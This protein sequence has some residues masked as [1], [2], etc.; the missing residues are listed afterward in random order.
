MKRYTFAIDNNFRTENTN[1]K[2]WSEILDNLIADNLKRNNSYLNYE[3]KPICANCPLKNCPLY[4]GTNLKDDLIIKAALYLSNNRN[5]IGDIR[6]EKGITYKLGS[7][8]IIFF[9][10][11]IQIGFDIFSY[12]DLRNASLLR[13]LDDTTRDTII[14]IYNITINI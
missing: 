7:T 9:D 12:D 3:T 8:P 5:R 6:C 10:D 14:H 1:T 4:K 11:E 13:T 2:S